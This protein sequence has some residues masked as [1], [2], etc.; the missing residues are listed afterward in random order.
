MGHNHERHIAI[1]LA[2][3]KG[4]RFKSK[5]PKVVHN[6][7]GKPMI[8]YVSLAAR[9]SNPERIIYV[10]GHGKDHV[11]KAINCL[12]CTYVEQKEQLGTGHA[13]AQT[14][15]Y[16]EN[17]DGI[18][19]ILNGD[20]PLV[21]GET[22]KNAVKYMEALMRFEGASVE[23]ENRDYRNEKI[24]GVVITTK[25]PNPL[26]YGRIIKDKHHRIIEIVEE[27]DADHQT[28]QINEI[29]TGIYLFYAPYLKEVIDKLQNDNAQN[30]YYLTDVV[31]LLNQ[32]G[33]EVYALLVPDYTQFIGVNDRWDL[34]KAENILRM[35]Y[36]QFWSYAGTTF[37]NP[38]T[39]YIEFDVELS[40]DVEVFPGVS[41]KGRTT[42]GE[43]TIIE[44]GVVL[45]NAKIGKNCRI[46]KGSVIEN[47][48][49]QDNAV[50]GPYARIR[51][52]AVIGQEA[53]IGNFV[54]VKN[55][56]I[57]EKTAA[58]HL[59]YIGD[60]EVGREVNIGAGTITCNYDGFQKHKTVIKDRA[61]IGSDTMLVAPI[62]VG[63]EA[64]TGSGS[65]ITKDVPD[66]ALAVERSPMKIVENY[67]EKRKKR[68]RKN[69]G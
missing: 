45:K 47:S 64:I 8:H 39:V 66:K 36:L 33:K 3:G 12:N 38:E 24:A 31:K 27:K 62:I 26:G 54:E 67:A 18:V 49:I 9:W 22:L 61:F 46:L 41:L 28:Q 13:V 56:T 63:E 17:F 10:V 6:I 44:E 34:A 40:P 59:S 55:S 48:T 19:M 1:I 53:Q 21:E 69:D 58:K 16:W 42:V 60:A 52:N 65:V 4:T 15:P 30:E 29:N 32:M 68:K 23:S 2:A 7:L 57:G 11:I 14:K 5:K 51:D 20:L 43:D 37:H 25:V 50:I 35:K